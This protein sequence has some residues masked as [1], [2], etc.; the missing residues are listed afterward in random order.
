M[1]DKLNL[2]PGTEFYP[3]NHEEQTV[4]SLKYAAEIFEIEDTDLTYDQ[5][6]LF[7]SLLKQG[8]TEKTFKTKVSS[9]IDESAVDSILEYLEDEFLL[10]N[11]S[12]NINSVAGRN[13]AQM[14]QAHYYYDLMASLAAKDQFTQNF[15]ANK[16]EKETIYLFGREYF[17]VTR[18]CESSII[19]S[20]VLGSNSVVYPMLADFY[21][22]EF[23]H[24]KIMFNALRPLLPDNCNMDSL[25]ILPS[26]Y[27]VMGLLRYLSYSDLLSF[28][29]VLFV[30]EGTPETS[31]A[32]LE[33]LKAYEV[34][35]KF[36]EMNKVHD[37]INTEGEHGNITKDLLTSQG[38][39]SEKK[40][41][42]MK[43]KMECL[44]YMRM[45]NL[46]EIVLTSY[47]NLWE[48]SSDSPLIA[49]KEE[50]TEKI[51]NMIKSMSIDEKRFAKE[52]VLSCFSN[53]IMKIVSKHSTQDYDNKKYLSNIAFSFLNTDN[54]SN[55][56]NI[57]NI[58][59]CLQ[60]ILTNASI[61]NE[62]GFLYLLKE[63]IH[64]DDGSFFSDKT[65]VYLDK[66]LHTLED[67]Q[68]NWK[69]LNSL[70]DSVEFL[71]THIRRHDEYECPYQ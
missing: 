63:F 43:T 65:S 10:I 70:V 22:E 46:N 58:Q 31:K 35:Q 25:P 11:K 17:H 20:M 5:I 15:M 55:S 50:L 41:L 59:Y 30:F 19:E 33:K 57:E 16:L 9:F 38:V 4:P 26:T 62:I 66:Y 71:L 6:T 39:I 61:D 34:D 51:S 37:D 13:A 21:K 36:F 48:R 12:D 47:K 54:S 2:I 60:A 1:L 32:Y 44:A 40:F 69:N 23:G 49:S 42:E 68:V 8:L 29:G 53:G 24:E 14:L 7:F 64:L 18:L 45:V 67:H 56:Q 28:M 52:H 3:G 27:I